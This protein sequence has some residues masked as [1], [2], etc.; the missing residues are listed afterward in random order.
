[1]GGVL[2]GAFA[3]LRV[4]GRRD[5]RVS[6]QLVRYGVLTT[7]VVALIFVGKLVFASRFGWDGMMPEN[8]LL[9]LMAASLLTVLVFQRGQLYDIHAIEAWPQWSGRLLTMAMLAGLLLIAIL[10]VLKVADE[11]SRIWLA[12]TIAGG[13]LVMW[14]M[15][16][17]VAAIVHRQVRSGALAR[18]VAIVGA[19]PQGLRFVERLRGNGEPRRRVIGVFDDR[20]TRLEPVD[21]LRFGGDLD[22]LEADVRCGQIDEVIVALPWSAED[23]IVAIINRLRELPVDVYLGSDLVAHRL[24]AHNSLL[25]AGLPAYQVVRVPFSGWAGI[26]KRLEDIFLAGVLLVLLAP[27]LAAIAVAIK[28]DSR[29]PVLFLQP[30]YGFNNRLIFVCKFRSMRHEPGARFHQATT[31]DPRVT[32]VGRFLRRNSLDELPQLFNVLAGTMSLVGPRPHPVEVNEQFVAVVDGYRG[33]HRVRP[34]ITGWAQIKGWRGE[35][36]TLDK[37]QARIAHDIHYIENWSIWFDL[38]I[39]ILTGLRGWRGPN[40]Y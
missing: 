24:P 27:L 15:R 31:A 13:V 35:T 34:G 5:I 6:E 7:D 33:R 20:R 19:G 14:A 3:P 39:L 32:R 4:G 12:A 26:A 37:M 22:Q 1:M 9:V 29:G 17:L 2:E 8:Y 18:S 11:F 25:F 38:R 21:G 16:G 40:A 10:H 30:R 36:E 28:F 23:R